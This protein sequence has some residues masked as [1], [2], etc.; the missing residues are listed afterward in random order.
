MNYNFYNYHNKRLCT[1]NNTKNGTQVVIIK[2]TSWIKQL[3]KS[4]FNHHRRQNPQEYIRP[5][6]L[7]SET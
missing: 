5:S 1:H 2:L 6:K 3:Q 4:G 7:H